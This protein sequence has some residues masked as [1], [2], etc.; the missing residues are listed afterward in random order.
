MRADSKTGPNIARSGSGYCLLSLNCYTS[1]EL[2]A[3]PHWRHKALVENAL[4]VELLGFGRTAAS[5]L[6]ESGGVGGYE[7]TSSEQ[8]GVDRVCSWSNA[9]VRGCGQEND[10]DLD[11][12]QVPYLRQTEEHRHDRYSTDDW[13]QKTEQ[14]ETE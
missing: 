1:E 2:A 11:S 10:P 9:R 8:P 6:S 12:V 13:R 5:L 4:G 14:E 3:A 7:H